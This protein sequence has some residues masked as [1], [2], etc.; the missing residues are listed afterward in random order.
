[1]RAQRLFA[2]TIGLAL[3]L[4]LTV[5]LTAYGLI[6]TEPG[7]RWLVERALSFAGERTVRIA[8]IRGRLIDHIELTD[9][10]IDAAGN[11][12]DVSELD[13][14]WSP[15]ALLAGEL[16]I[17]RL[18]LAGVELTPAPT[19]PDSERPASISIPA[20][21]LPGAIRDL[22]LRRVTI[23]TP[24]Q[25]VVI[26]ELSLAANWDRDRMNLTN[27]ILNASDHRL[28]ADAILGM[29]EAA[30]HELKASWR[31]IVGDGP[32][33]ATIAAAGPLDELTVALDLDGP[34]VAQI[35]G[36]VRPLDS[37]PGVTLRGRVQAPQLDAAV[38]FGDIDLDLDGDL[39]AL[40]V[41]VSTRAGRTG[42]DEYALTASA[43][44]GLEATDDATATLSI[45]WRAVPLA[46]NLP[47][48]A[49]HGQ[50][51][52]DG[53]RVALTHTTDAPLA[54]NLSGTVTLGDSAPAL[55]LKLAWQDFV[56]P[57]GVRND[58]I[59]RRG[60]ITA[61]GTPDALTLVIAGSFEGTPVGP[62][63]VDARG[64]LGSSSL[65]VETLSARLLKGTIDTGGTFDWRGEPTATL[66]FSARELD[67][68]R[69]LAESPSRV[70][71]AGQGTFTA[72]ANGPRATLEL[73]NIGGELR[74]HE[75]SGAASLHTSPEAIVVDSARFA[76][77][78]NR[79][80]F[81]GTWSDALDGEFDIALQDLATLD[82]RLS[83]SLTGQ[84]EVGG[85][86]LRPRIDAELA[87][88]GLQFDRFTAADLEANIDV[89]LA[90][91]ED[92]QATLN[93]SGLKLDGDALG[94]VS[95]SGSGTAAAHHLRLSFDGP[96][97]SV[98]TAAAGHFV[99]DKWV[100]EVAELDA[101]SSITGAWNLTSP[102]TVSVSGN[103]A[104]IADTCLESGAAR[105]CITASRLP[106][107]AKARIAVTG[108]PLALA[109]F[110]LPRT[111]HLR[112]RLHGEVEVVHDGKH[113][114]GSGSLAVADGIVQ[115][116]TI[117]GAP[118]EVA[119]ESLAATFTLSPDSITA[120]MQANVER[121]LDID[122][123]VSTGRTP[124]APL[125]GTLSARATDL[126]WLAEFAPELAGTDGG[127]EL[128]TTLDGSRSAPRGRGRLT[129][130]R[131]ALTLPDIGLVIDRVNATFDASPETIIFDAALGAGKGELRAQ[132]EA[133]KPA[134]DAHW[135]YT[136]E[137]GGQDFPLVRIPE[138]EADV[139]PDLKLAGDDQGL[140]ISGTL[141]VPR[142]AIDV[143]RL[144]SS[145]V[146]VSEDEIIVVSD[147]ADVD[148]TANRGFMTESVSGDVA[149]R[150][151]D[152]ISVNGF[153]LTS[154]LS[155]GVDWKKR[156]GEPLG[157]A[158]GR[159]NIDE[160]EFKAYG[161][162]L[163]IENG[164]IVFAGPV[165]NPNLNLRAYRPGL[166][167]KAGVTV[168]GTVREPKLS[169][170]S[171]PL[172][173]DGD[174][175][176]YIITGRALS[177]ASAGESSILAQ[178]ALSL[179]AEESAAVTNQIRGKFGLDEFSVNAGSTVQDTSLV[180]GKRLSPKLTV[181][182]D[183]NPFEHLWT[184]FLNYELTP[185][186]SV[187]AESGERQGAD[188]L[189]SVEGEDLIET[190]S[191]FSK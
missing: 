186:W 23:H 67:F 115:R 110:Y 144:P 26:D 176:S 57:L 35:T 103:D 24:E 69:F 77:G 36:T 44:L 171:E 107:G 175:L 123:S 63:D 153:G 13:F 53:D 91:S 93:F 133:R 111:M 45:D 80:A 156:R 9:V 164:R 25:D 94:D 142:V 17:E 178:A 112:G 189:Y 34:L 152:N 86:L 108:V 88:R 21:P 141:N 14:S 72:G 161:Q 150:L 87:G 106:S 168:R 127:L 140:H 41:T 146:S 118:E 102:S 121:W 4:A 15:R 137:L 113:L 135:Q 28:T 191:P 75:I 185:N 138:A 49:G 7:S 124:D 129:L 3:G 173:S 51:S 120:D 99:G 68:S 18:R 52:L 100:A 19:P 22:T 62:L 109:D 128:T 40:A 157:R 167:V 10:A 117:D 29:G 56:I 139:T 8:R 147:D 27:V 165:D 132:G 162:Q 6:A 50:F 16:L 1:M 158:S 54:T 174:T 60:T 38:T 166:D 163:L 65:N 131:G 79:L 95:L 32:A 97:A 20:L 74:G 125:A 134:A 170:F 81:R 39:A 145:A 126:A 187:E 181:R 160:G 188:L 92:S 101:T 143:K 12:I 37:R 84:G 122:G 183:Y 130:T 172:Q 114:T 85:E 104:V 78:R 61:V 116:E 148:E 47:T 83:G 33:S 76:A 70:E 5:M 2:W 182:T 151:G 30:T 71:F 105:V 136:V 58:I 119:I 184:F 154:K 73:E 43:T 46:A 82:P 149:I 89:D 169:L 180:A 55:D 96:N 90:R 42:S 155:G 98:E 159:I 177:D 59:G 11:R 31:G 48:V 179:G 64:K 66:R 190:L